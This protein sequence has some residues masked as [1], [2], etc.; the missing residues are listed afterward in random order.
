KCFVVCTYGISRC[1]GTVPLMWISLGRCLEEN[2]MLCRQSHSSILDLMDI[3]RCI[4]IVPLTWTSF[5]RCLERK[6]HAPA[7]TCLAHEIDNLFPEIHYVIA[8]LNYAN[9][10][11]LDCLKFLDKNNCSGI[12][13]NK[14]T[15]DKATK[16]YKNAERNFKFK[17]IVA[18]FVQMDGK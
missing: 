7:R 10:N 12:S 5:D 4:G 3:L 1:V 11:I 8:I 17:E 18:F 15:H 2:V 6:S 9:W 13:S 16:L 14:K